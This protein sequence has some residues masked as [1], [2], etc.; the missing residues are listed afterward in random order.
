MDD[1]QT[2]AEKSRHVQVDFG[3]F[4]IEFRTRMKLQTESIT[5]ESV[6]I[7]TDFKIDLWTRPLT[8]TQSNLL[9][10]IKILASDPT[11][12]NLLPSHTQCFTNRFAQPKSEFRV[13]EPFMEGNK[14]TIMTQSCMQFLLKEAD[15]TPITRNITEPEWFVHIALDEIID[16]LHNDTTH[17]LI[18]I[19]SRGRKSTITTTPHQYIAMAQAAEQRSS[20]KDTFHYKKRWLDDMT[21]EYIPQ[22]QPLLG[23][24][25]QTAPSHNIIQVFAGL[26][27]KELTLEYRPRTVPHHVLWNLMRKWVITAMIKTHPRP[28]GNPAS[29]TQ[30]NKII[31][32][33]SSTPDLKKVHQINEHRP[34]NTQTPGTNRHIRIN[35]EAVWHIV[36]PGNL[37]AYL[38]VKATVHIQSDMV[39]IDKP[40][41]LDLF[42]I[43]SQHVRKTIAHALHELHHNHNFDLESRLYCQNQTTEFIQNP[44]GSG[45]IIVTGQWAGKPQH[46]LWLAEIND[47]CIQ[48][49]DCEYFGVPDW[50]TLMN[51][52]ME[53]L[54]G[55]MLKNLTYQLQHEATST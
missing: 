50:L 48:R 31:P 8:I 1:E 36:E 37:S 55:N 20:T 27:N 2:L 39:L 10:S 17:H 29:G 9:T 16:V 11:A 19:Y 18:D 7:I 45:T 28:E 5:W 23:D 40:A 26:E 3:A 46:K 13:A 4:N 42:G 22:N 47:H 52:E 32:R 12:W 34:T 51:M 6:W 38:V 41:N 25:F 33:I 14:T 54:L 15:D 35:G 24:V 53:N 49:G 44:D 21:A 43:V 30:R